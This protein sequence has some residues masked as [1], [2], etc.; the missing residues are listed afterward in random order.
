V[1]RFEVKVNT[2]VPGV[3]GAGV[4]VRRTVVAPTHC[5]AVALVIDDVVTAEMVGIWCVRRRGLL[6]GRSRWG[7][8]ID[9]SGGDG[10]SGVREPRRPRPPSGAASAALDLPAA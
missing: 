10:L 6:R 7:G 2:M 3:P 5:A 9:G 8:S 4:S 1:P